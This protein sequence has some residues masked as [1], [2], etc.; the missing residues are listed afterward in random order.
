MISDGQIMKTDQMGRVRTP[1]ARQ[2]ELLDEFEHSGLSGPKFA[3]LVGLKY[4]TFA[5]WITRRRKGKQ[6]VAP[7]PAQAQGDSV[8]WIEA[9]VDQALP[10]S[11]GSALVIH[12]PG[13]A[14]TEVADGV[15]AAL[16]AQLLRLLHKEQ[17]GAC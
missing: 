5:A 4:Q 11:P 13:G 6:S 9:M 1:R 16:V 3:A 15:Q 8:H 2:E 14:R 17:P 10:K 12:L 7:K